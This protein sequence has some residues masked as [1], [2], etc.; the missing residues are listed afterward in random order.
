MISID[1]LQRIVDVKVLRVES[2]RANVTESNCDI[3]GR[4]NVE[5]SDPLVFWWC[6]AEYLK[7]NPEEVVDMARDQAKI[8]LREALEK[9][10]EGL[11]NM[12]E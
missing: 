11:E 6:L 1:T 5:I 9:A 7:A 3:S 10:L 4:L 2:I 8:F 12:E